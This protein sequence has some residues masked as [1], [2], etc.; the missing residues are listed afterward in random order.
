[1]RQVGFLREALLPEAEEAYRIASSSYALG[2]SSALEVLD[3][4]RSL[5]DAQSQ[6][7]DALGAANDAI[8]R[9]ELAAGGSLDSQDVEGADDDR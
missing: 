1:L 4:K 7:A 9:L 8:A 5:L 2:G 6:Y 3:A